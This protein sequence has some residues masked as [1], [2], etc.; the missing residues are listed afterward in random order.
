MTNPIKRAM[1]ILAIRRDVLSPPQ[2]K[3]KELSR[4]PICTSSSDKGFNLV[5][6]LEGVL[7]FSCASLRLSLCLAAVAKSSRV[8]KERYC[9][10]KV[11][12][13]KD[14]SNCVGYISRD[15]RKEAFHRRSDFCM[16]SGCIS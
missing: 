11:N 6:D 14:Q 5:V 4:R 3:G 2:I 13:W 12:R 10:N 9:D 1:Q 7:E 15:A 16:L 8:S